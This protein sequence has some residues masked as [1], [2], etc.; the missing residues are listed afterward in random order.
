MFD[1]LALYTLLHSSAL[2]NRALISS[3]PTLFFML[4]IDLT[5]FHCGLYISSVDKM[6]FGWSLIKPYLWL[7]IGFGYF[8]VDDVLGSYVVK[9]TF[10]KMS[11]I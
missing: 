5:I 11:G 7:E 3:L 9:L 10:M 1:S 6:S 4:V 8:L 2:S